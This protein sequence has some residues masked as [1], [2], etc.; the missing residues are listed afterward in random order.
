MNLT[1][2]LAWRNLWRNRRRTLFTLTAMSVSV[3]FLI[4]LLAMYEGMFVDAIGSVT[5]T[6]YGHVQLT[7][8]EFLTHP[9]VY[10]T[11]PGD[12]PPVP[13]KSP[14][15]AATPRLQTFALA[16]C[17]RESVPAELVGVDPTR[18]PSVTRML[19]GLSDGRPL[20]PKGNGVLVGVGLQ[21]NLG[22]QVGDTLSVLGQAAD[23]SLL[24]ENLQVIGILDVG[25]PL[26]NGRLVVMPLPTLQTLL[27]L[28]DRAHAWVLRL[29]NPFL[30]TS[31]AA[32]QQTE[33]FE[34]HPWTDFLPAMGDLV[35]LWRVGELITALI[36]Y[37]AVV[38][39]TL[40]TLYMMFFER[41]PEFAVLQAVGM[42][43]R[44]L[45]GMIM[46]E[47][48]LLSLLAAAIGGTAGGV[49]SL[50]FS[51]HPLDFSRWVEPVSYGGTVIRPQFRTLAT[52]ISVGL[53]VVLLI[54]EGTLVALFPARK[55][56]K[57]SITAI[58][59]TVRT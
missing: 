58:L 42:K 21:H 59:R 5:E 3:L 13:L 50:W 43:G 53:P 40:N 22:C 1:W 54:L 30:A 29:R 23:G 36:F 57:L 55:L 28:P 52:P 56:R 4:F 15:V 33:G 27:N 6:Y 2:R 25:N 10:H 34:V 18:E 20:P 37:F 38:L 47:A 24:A 31:W 14:V 17:G 26:L 35:G 44:T 32:S 8:P 9:R 41:I 19:S 12:T 11:L 16:T 39:I 45:S 48:F 51:A 49:L 7:P 46:K